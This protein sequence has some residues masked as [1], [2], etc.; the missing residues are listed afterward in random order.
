M[1]NQRRKQRTIFLTCNETIP[2]P[3]NTHAISQILYCKQDYNSIDARPLGRR[4]TRRTYIHPNAK[5][6]PPNTTWRCSFRSYYP[7]NM[8]ATVE[9]EPTT[10]PVDS[11]MSRNT[12]RP[13]FWNSSKISRSECVFYPRAKFKPKVPKQATPPPLPF[14]PLEGICLQAPPPYLHCS[15]FAHKHTSKPRTYRSS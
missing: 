12:F 15:L 1:R 3:T 8:N 13:N 6:T 4:G 10:I 2:T 5:A 11:G 9:A 7:E 14:G